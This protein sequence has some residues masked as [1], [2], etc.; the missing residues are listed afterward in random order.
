[1]SASVPCVLSYQ[2]H[3]PCPLQT[4]MNRAEE[5]EDG[6]AISNLQGL[7]EVQKLSGIHFVEEIAVASRGMVDFPGAKYSGD[8]GREIW[9]RAR[10]AHV[11]RFP[12]H[13]TK[14][15]SIFNCGLFSVSCM[16]CRG[17][18]HN[19]PHHASAQPSCRRPVCPALSHQPRRTWHAWRRSL[20][21]SQV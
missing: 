6:C 15:E 20:R 7:E 12:G 3:V 14:A 8:G 11:V 5:R 16:S 18:I 4:P 10:Q 17:S 1:M 21:P 9:D 2:E 19:V 13:F